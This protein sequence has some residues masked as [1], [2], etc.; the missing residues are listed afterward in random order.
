MCLSSRWGFDLDT[1]GRRAHCQGPAAN[2]HSTMRDEN[3][4]DAVHNRSERRRAA[5]TALAAEPA[6]RAAER[7]ILTGSAAVLAETLAVSTAAE[8]RRRL[9]HVLELKARADE[10]AT[11]RDAYQRAADDLRGWAATNYLAALREPRE[12]LLH[13]TDRAGDGAPTSARPRNPYTEESIS[14]RR[15]RPRPPFPGQRRRSPFDVG[16]AVAPRVAKTPHEA[17]GERR[18]G[19]AAVHEDSR[20]TVAAG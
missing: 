12:C 6:V 16:D 14:L 11:Q 20:S 18:V 5:W 13:V 9:A 17:R 2:A 1:L 7:A 8:A 4:E 19:G 10:D 3:K 15:S